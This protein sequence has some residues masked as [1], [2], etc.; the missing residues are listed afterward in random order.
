MDETSPRYEGWRVAAA[1]SVGV[2][3]GFASLLVYTFGIFLRPIADEFGWSRESVSAAFGIAAM[4]VA[5]CSPGLGYLLDRLHPRRVIVPCVAV[6]GLA[7]ASLSLLTPN[8]WHLYAV[9]F[10]I[11]VVGNGTAQMAYARAVSSWFVARRGTAVAV[12]MAGGAVGAMVLPPLAEALIRDVGWRTA[13]L[14]LGLMPVVVGVPGAALFIRERGGSEDGAAAIGAGLH[15]AVPVAGATV[16]EGLTSRVFWILVVVLFFSSIAQNAALTHLPA[17]LSDRGVSTSGAALAL[18]A[19]GAA[20]LVG[21]L[22]T[23]W[24]LDRF[25]AG[26]VAFVNLAVA[27]AGV[28]WLAQAGSLTSGV[29]AAG[30]IGFGMGGEADVTPY[31]LSRY[32]GLRSFSVLYGFTWTFYAVAGAL[33]PVLMGRAFDLTGS[34]Q[35]FL[36]Q[37]AWGTLAVATLMLLLPRYASVP[38]A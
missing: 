25:F 24:M 22:A 7:F 15:A 38:R 27:A 9:F 17:L 19:L 10:A 36:V 35:T 1:S 30:L 4:T 34:Y 29:V 11:G 23:G 14:S 5:A 26:R 16:H 28:Y 20:S 8:L 18:S 31:A 6:F 2:F 32:F 21:R 12:V 3:V 13:C 37:V 33:G